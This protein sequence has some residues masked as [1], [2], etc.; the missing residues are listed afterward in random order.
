MERPSIF[1]L[2]SALMD[3]YSNFVHAFVQIADDRLADYVARALLEEE[4]L[5]P[6]PLIQLS[7]AYRRAAT[8][9]ELVDRGWLHPETARI[10]HTRRGTPIRLYQHQVEAIEKARRGE[11]FVVTSGTGS[12]KSFCYFIPIVD[13][14]VRLQPPAP[15]ERRGPVAIIIYPM[16][17]LVN[18]QV[19][20][21]N[22]LKNAYEERTGVPF[23]VTFARYTGETPEEEREGI[24]K[25]PPHILLTNYMMAELLLVRPEDSALREAPPYPGAPFYL[26]FDELHT[27]RGRQGA[28]VAMLVRRLKARLNREQV[29]HIGTSATMVAHRDATSQERRQVVADFAARFF[30][31]PIQAEHIIEETLEPVTTGGPP[32]AEEVRQNFETPFPDDLDAFRR[33]ALVRW[34]EYALGIEEE[35]GG[36]LRRRVPRPLSA[37]AQDLAQVVGA[38]EERCRDRLRELLLHAVALNPPDEEPVFAFKLHQ[39]IS[40]GRAVYATLEPPDRRVFSLWGEGSPS[41]GKVYYPLRF[42]R[43]CGQEY[44]HVLRYDGRLLPFP[45]GSNELDEGMQAGYVFVPGPDQ[46]WGPEQIPDDW[47]GPN[48]RLSATWKNR[49]PEP[50]WVREDGTYSTEEIPDG[51]RAWWQG[52]R[53]WL[54]LHCGEYYTGRE[55]EYTKLAGLSSEGRSSATT[56]LA[57]SL[58]RH[59]SRTGAARDKL[60]TF[61][62]NR[63]D[64]SLQAGHFNDFVQMAVLRAAL[65]SALKDHREL[66]FANLADRVIEYMGLSLNDIAQSPLAPDTPAAKQV[67]NVFRD[68]TA[69]RLYDDLRRNRRVVQPNLEDVGLLRVE[70][71]GLRDGC[72]REDVWA[73]VPALRDLSPEDRYMLVRAVLDHFRHYF[74]IHTPLLERQRL[75]EL[76]RRSEQLLNEF[77]GLDPTTETLYPATWFVRRG[78]SSRPVNGRQLSARTALGRFLRRR[79]NL[80]R[81]DYDTFMEVFLDVLVRQG[82]LREL[83]P[84]DDHRRYRL[85]AAALRWRLGDGTPLPPDPIYARRA[86]PDEVPQPVNAFFQ[87][88]YQEPAQ[89]LVALE[90]REH[91]AQVVAPGERERRERRFRWTAQDQADPQLR[92][93]LPYLVC[94]PTM[95]LGIDIADL[96]LVHLRNVPPTPANYAQRSGRAGRQGQPGL[97]ITY[98][99]AFSNH[100]QYFFRH[101]EEMVAGEVRAPRLDLTNEALVRAHIHAEWLAQVSLSM[102]QSIEEVIDTAILPDLPLRE[103]VRGQI[104][105]GQ[106][107]RGQLRE[108]VRRMLAFDRHMLQQ[109]G[110]FTEEWVDRVLDEAPERFDRAFDRW[111]DLFRMATEQ[112][113]QATQAMLTAR[114]HEEQERAQRSLDEAKRQRN[115]LLQIEVAREESDFYPYRYL[116]SEGFLPGYNFPALPVRAW[117][118]RGNGEFISRP[119]FLAIR[120]FGPQNIVYHE[121]AKWEVESF[122]EPPGGLP[123]RL[124]QKRL[125]LTCGAFD[126]VHYDRCPVCGTLFNASNSQIMPLL[127]MPNVRLRR[128]E[129]I[130]CNEEER[131]RRGYRL[132]VAYRFAP[133]AEGHRI[134]QAQVLVDEQPILQLVYAP[135]ATIVVINQ[136]W[137]TR[138]EGFLVDLSTG[139]LLKEGDLATD[140]GA[141][142]STSAPARVHLYVQ[143]TQNMLLVRGADPAL[144]RDPE[145]E[146][147]LRYAL[148]RGVEQAFQL[149]ESELAVVPIGEGEWRALLFYEAAEG[150]VG[151][152]RRLVEEPDAMARIAQE[153]LSVCHFDLHGHDLK[154]NACR[155]ACYECLLSY[156]NQLEAHR[157]NRYRIVDLLL[158]LA[159]SRTAMQVGTRSRKE[160]FRWLLSFVDPRSELERIFLETLYQGDYRLPD[161]AQK[162]IPEVHAIA[163]FFY[164]PN[165]LVFCDG[166]I[167]DE[168]Q[169]RERDRRI[170]RGLIALGYRVIVIRYD[171]DI[172]EQIRAYPDVFGPGGQHS[173]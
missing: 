135:A 7:P 20:A 76:R 108:R 1:D 130:T 48:G 57:V 30:G 139:R 25:T 112:F 104:R 156:Q 111:R 53:F 119:R 145:V 83:E 79:L 59:A 27:Y 19:A 92:R 62:D 99:G 171:K 162:A 56:V 63:Q 6:E 82:F 94:S 72:A 84:V 121:G 166:A 70:Y 10:F 67:W 87:R 17:A 35:A 14:V 5:W 126:E 46:E 90:A 109:T 52:E 73:S 127:E 24:R 37:V 54:C 32:T 71:R 141:G 101:R 129:R 148:K 42:C 34:T 97:I 11:S 106:A 22:A 77:W 172:E 153:A 93:R 168:P 137:R 50:I 151:V 78:T 38:S 55:S 58:L 49:V 33:H 170:R 169:Q 80:S 95:E 150:G 85:D 12:G 142:P 173:G 9:D 39:F 165:V 41:E 107:A 21:L 51:I 103:N 28:D 136:G 3:D 138:P 86:Q 134:Q 117:V 114:R 118:P 96:D 100:D 47:Y 158:A 167:H 155:G 69:Y 146:T 23:P 8:V 161:E 140:Y 40:Q 154:A 133:A 110:W 43:V 64:A 4:H 128:R 98:C 124:T 102:R 26:V 16:N 159:E 116:A 164:E 123:Q 66:D 144:L 143:D 113:H 15:D 13:T 120:E 29:I 163:D 91:T 31:H 18:S 105:L 45:L 160:H 68:L 61:T 149:E 147:T 157:L 60:L 125:C 2:H 44:Y 132:Q 131:L 81:E 36:R 65:Y 75:Q 88:F 152:L 115:L 122:Q 89:D 74:A